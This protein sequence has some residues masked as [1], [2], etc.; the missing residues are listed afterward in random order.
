MKKTFYRILKVFAIAF[1]L[2]ACVPL[3]QFRDLQDKQKK[4][5][6]ERDMLKSKND[7][8]IIDT[9]EMAANIRRLQKQISGLVQDTAL[10]G[11]QYRNLE[12]QYKK[13]L[14]INKELIESHDAL[15]K[16]SAE[17]AKKLLSKLQQDQEDLQ[18][19][20]NE[21]HGLEITLDEKKKN[22]DELQNE[23]TEKNKQLEERN[24]KL[25]ELESMLN[26]KDSI[27]KALKTKVSEALNQF[28]KEGLSVQVRNGKVYVS[29]EEKLLF[30]SGKWDVDP[31]GV[32][33]IKKLAGVLEKDPDINVMIEGH[34]D[35][36]LYKGDSQ[37]L[38]NWD[39][40]VKR[41]TSIVRILLAGTKID[42]KRLSVAGRSEYQPVDN[43]KT[44]EARQKNRRTEIILTPK[45][46]ELFKILENQ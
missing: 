30:K 44:P 25:V 37:I 6:D 32:N 34:T 31:K 23:L 42:P 17:E 45:L 26:K 22:L 14:E 15:T 16:G 46:D 21:M 11:K 1:L 28:E 5:N 2:F 35:D 29:L 40:S 33:A 41:A 20:E 10:L 9:T 12:K 13:S 43:A 27:V 7:A 3:N 19:Q 36:V 39:L 8:L 38:D 4:C 24:K 18:K